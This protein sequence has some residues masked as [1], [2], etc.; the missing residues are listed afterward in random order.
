MVQGNGRGLGE[1][2]GTREIGSLWDPHKQD[3]PL[4]SA[5]GGGSG[6]LNSSTLKAV[7]FTF[8]L[9]SGKHKRTCMTEEQKVVLLF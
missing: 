8:L 5:G 1:M 6:F 7:T 3:S 2:G 9:D 4:Q